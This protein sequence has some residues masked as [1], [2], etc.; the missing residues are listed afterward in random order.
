MVNFLFDKNTKPFVNASDLYS[1]FGVSSSSGSAR[2]KLIRELF[3]MFP[4]DPNWTL[5]SRQYDN[6]LIWLV[7]VNGH[8]VDIR[9]M[10]LEVQEQA[11]EQNIIPFIP[12]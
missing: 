3:D 2:S 12:Q 10:P 4:S 6:P 11:F 9:Q 7:S 5:P 1:D 8:I